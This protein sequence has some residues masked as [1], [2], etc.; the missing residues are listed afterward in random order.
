MKPFDISDIPDPIGD[1]MYDGEDEVLRKM[2]VEVR[3]E[4]LKPKPTLSLSQWAEMYAQLSLET[5]STKGKFHAYEYQK[6]MMDAVTD[7]TVERITVIKS[8]R[9][10]YTKVLDNVVG[11][12]LH[13]DPCP[14]LI[15]QPRVEDAEDYSR[16]EIAPMLRDTPVLAEIAGDLKAKDSNQRIA[17]RLFDNGASISFIGANTPAGF[18]RITARIAMFDEVDGYPPFG[19]GDEGDQVALG[20]K[21]TETFWNR[22]IILGSTPKRKATSRI[23]RSWLQ[24]DQRYYYVPCPHCGKYQRLK[25][26]RFRYKKVDD[27]TIDVDSVHYLCDSKRKCQIEESHKPSMIGR[28]EWRSTKRFKGHAGFSIWAAYSLFPNAAWHKLLQEYIDVKDDPTE[29]KT[30]INVVRGEP[31]EDEG[32]KVD[33]KVLMERTENWVDG[34]E[35]KAD[36]AIFVITIGVD[37]HDDRVEFERVGWGRNEESW[38][39]DQDAIYG[40]PSAPEFWQ[41]LDDY[42]RTPTDIADGRKLYPAATCIDSG[43]HYTDAVYKFVSGKERRHVW[44]VKGSSSYGK[45]SMRGAPIWPKVAS[46]S[47]KSGVANFFIIGVAEAKDIIYSRNR[48]KPPEEEGQAF[49]AGFP[50]YPKSRDEEYFNQMTSEIVVTKTHK[51]FP[52]REWA[53]KPGFKNEK[54]DIRVYAFAALRSL[55]INW[56]RMA[57]SV[58]D[59]KRVMRATQ[60]INEDD[61]VAEVPL[62]ELGVP[63]AADITQATSTSS[64]RF[65]QRR[66]SRSS[67]LNR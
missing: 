40:D 47:K 22:K 13:Q 20:I 63:S 5:S 52:Y 16:T 59:E 9:I 1:A 51:G 25:W 11:Y 14:Q 56:G 62:E 54:L 65:R 21:R 27:E 42:V 48:L 28:G 8:A 32:E 29:L 17:K 49:P 43:G 6:G 26:E 33:G 44:A 67:M 15:V 34:P 53:L 37:V 36:P 3:R 46:R 23:Y 45:A 4:C 39:L 31:W 50:H 60:P 35:C 55:R 18:R 24:S 38:S 57:R 64:P 58:V 66:T 12:F 30:Y 41:E 7:P 10:G 2:L 19:A 61:V